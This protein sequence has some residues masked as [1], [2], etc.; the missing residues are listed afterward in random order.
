MKIRKYKKVQKIVSFVIVL[1]FVL[2]IFPDINTNAA[3]Y[4]A[5][6]YIV[7]AKMGGKVTLKPIVYK[8]G[9]EISI[10][11][12]D[13]SVVWCRV[14]KVEGG[15]IDYERKT[16]VIKKIHADWFYNSSARAK[17][18]YIVNFKD[19]EIARGTIRILCKGKVK[20]KRVDFKSAKLTKEGTVNLKYKNTK[21]TTGFEIMYATNEK[22]TENKKT[23]QMGNVFGKELD[24]L[25]EGN[26]Y[27][28]KIRGVAKINKKKAYGKWSKI[29]KVD[30]PAR[31]SITNNNI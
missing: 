31:E 3:T 4:T 6:N 28:I 24:G 17:H 12:K 19:K 15:P 1:V 22:F 30:I 10:S 27:F 18:T 29:L 11:S 9:K 14:S 5:K 26:T 7:K 13:Y 21:D 2:S 16:K 20:V 25:K 23:I 8:D